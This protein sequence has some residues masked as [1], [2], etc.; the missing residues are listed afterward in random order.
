MVGN[1]YQWCADYHNSDYRPNGKD[2]VDTKKSNYRCIRGGAWYDDEP[3]IFRCAEHSGGSRGFRN[4]GYGFRLS[5][6]PK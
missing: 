5:A 2:P 6:G 3:D 4:G 1:V